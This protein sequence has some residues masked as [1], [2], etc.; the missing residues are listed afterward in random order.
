[1]TRQTLT[2]ARQG[3]LEGALIGSL[4]LAG[5]A[6]SSQQSPGPG[7]R[8]G[9]GSRSPCAANGTTCLATAGPGACAYSRWSAPRPLPG[10]PAGAVIRSPYQATG[11]ETGYVV[12]NN[13]PL[14]DSLPAPS[15]P[16]I[17]LTDRGEDI[18]RPPGDF[19]FAEPRAFVDGRG[20]LHVVWAEPAE[21]PVLRVDWP[22]MI[23]DYASLWHATYTPRRGWTAPEQ[24]H[25]GTRISWY[26]G[27][28]DMVLARDGA[29]HGI[30]ADDA[31][32]GLYHLTFSQGTWRPR[33][34][35]GIERRPAYASVAVSRDG[36]V[37]VPFVAAAGSV[38]SVRSDAADQGVRSDANSVFLVRSLDGGRTWLS[39]QLISRSGSRQASQIRVL[40]APDGTVHLVWAQNLSGG[41]TPEVVRHAASRDGGETWSAPDDVDIPDRLGYLQAVLDPCGAVHMTH[42]ALTYREETDTDESRIWYAR[43]NGGWTA[44]EQPF[45]DLN[46]TEGTL[47]TT[48]DGS[49]R[50]VWSVV[51]LGETV[52]QNTFSAVASH[53]GPP[54]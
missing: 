37:Y 38:P 39:P 54:P 2:S 33:R 12:G 44:L 46:S 15:R 48:R 18:G 6:P 21:R 36:R 43:W 29:L 27:M 13:V 11:A 32:R 10:V 40:V 52:Y 41:L 34:I 42:E 26:H 49:P 9:A 45:G 53:L 23:F 16:L 3:L 50:L 5:C 7:T 17:A 31:V 25:A 24:V 20:T 30:T 35:P 19:V 22:G 1:M 51:H 47:T 8:G 28:G 4:L 14:F